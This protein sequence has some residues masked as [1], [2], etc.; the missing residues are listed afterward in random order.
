MFGSIPEDTCD[1]GNLAVLQ[2]D[3]NYLKGSIP[4]EIGNCSSLY[5]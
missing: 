4:E 1:S 3:G 5:L 2:L